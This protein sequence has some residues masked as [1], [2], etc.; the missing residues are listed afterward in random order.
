MTLEYYFAIIGFII[1]VASW[2]ICAWLSRKNEREKVRIEQ[3][4]ACLRK[5]INCL[6][7]WK[8]LVSE[9]QYNIEQ[10]RKMAEEVTMEIQ[11]IGSK[12]EVDNWLQFCE[13]NQKSQFEQIR[14]KYQKLISCLI[15]SYRKTIGVK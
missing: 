5:A 14:P 1:T 4:L 13:V 3:K 11:L 15:K 9:E 7:V 12:E 8:K 6:Q 2:Y 10:A